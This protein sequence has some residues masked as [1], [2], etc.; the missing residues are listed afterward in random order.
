MAG[1]ASGIWHF[2]PTESNFEGEQDGVYQSPLSIIKN[3]AGE[4]TIYQVDGQRLDVVADDPTLKDPAEIT[5][6]H[7]Y[8][9]VNIMRPTQKAGYAFI[10][11]ISESEM[12]LAASKTGTCPVEFPSSG[13]KTYYR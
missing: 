6:E 11:M 2:S 13:T 1:T 7:C 4:V 3:S 8:Q 10:K 12:M 5:G 9:A